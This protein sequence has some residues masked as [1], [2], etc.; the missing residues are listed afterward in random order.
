MSL[1]FYFILLAILILFAWDRHKKA[2]ALTFQEKA[3]VLED[4]IDLYIKEGRLKK[5]DKAT[6]ALK[7]SVHSLTENLVHISLWHVLY[8][9]FKNRHED[10]SEYESVIKNARKNK[11]FKELYDDKTNLLLN[12][13]KK[14]HFITFVFILITSLPFVGSVILMQKW[15]KYLKK[16]FREMVYKVEI[17]SDFSYA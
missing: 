3:E 6:I 8:L 5:H 2:I 14:R 15:S 12:Y 1:S 11:V 17:E 4:K 7:D 9:A 13:F 16:S 10:L